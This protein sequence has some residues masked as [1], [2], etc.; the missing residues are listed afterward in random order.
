MKKKQRA[1]KN[2][3]SKTNNKVIFCAC[4]SKIMMRYYVYSRIP[5]APHSP[6]FLNTFY[7]FVFHQSLPH[8]PQAKN[9]S[10]WPERATRIKSDW[11]DRKKTQQERGVYL[12]EKGRY[13]RGESERGARHRHKKSTPV[14]LFRPANYR[15]ATLPRSF[16]QNTFFPKCFSLPL[17]VTISFT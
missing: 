16:P 13:G 1:S 9:F 5:L 2:Q 11:K 3:L 6:Y 7:H 17:H 4:R 14:R 10:H 8:S 15:T 12:L